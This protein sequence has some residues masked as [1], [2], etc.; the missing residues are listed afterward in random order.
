MQRGNYVALLVSALALAV[1]I[2]GVLE[3]RAAARR[4]ERLRLSTLIADLDGLYFEQLTSPDGLAP[5][6]FTD[7]INSRR[8]LMSMQALALLPGFR[9]EVTSAELRILAYA[10]NRAGYPSES[11]RVWLGAIA[12]AAGE[13]ATQTLFARRGY[14]YFLFN[15]GRLDDARGQMRVAVESATRDD[16]SQVK[17]IETL[18]C[19]AVEE[20]RTV[21]PS[22]AAADELLTEARQLADQIRTPRLRKRMHQDLDELAEP[23]AADVFRNGDGR[24]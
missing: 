18:K 23:T 3:R 21:P 11:D 14:G 24:G 19:W 2:Y 10:L 12:V 22:R 5:G 13:G 16:D 8:E 15:C 1:A 4:S 6:D 7:G 20:F 17:A 9:K